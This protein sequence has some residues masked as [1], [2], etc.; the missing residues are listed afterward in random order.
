MLSRLLSEL[1]QIELIHICQESLVYVFL[2][3]E[4]M[5]IC[6]KKLVKL[7]V[8]IAIQQFMLHL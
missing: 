5:M 7:V 2:V 1:Q 3:E 8:P 4:R 6:Q